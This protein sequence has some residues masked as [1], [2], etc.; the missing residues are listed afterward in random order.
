[1]SKSYPVIPKKLLSSFVVRINGKDQCVPANSNILAATIAADIYVPRLCYHPD[2][3]PAEKCEICLVKVNG[4]FEVLACSTPIQ[5]QM[6]IETKS[7]EVVEHAFKHFELLCNKSVMPSSPEIEEVFKYFYGKGRK[8]TR[9]QEFTNSLVYDPNEC[10]NCER[11][12]RACNVVQQIGAVSKDTYAMDKAK[13][14][15]CGNCVSVCPTMGLREVSAI[16][17]VLRA[18]AAGRTM[19]LQLAPAVRVSVAEL[20]GFPVGTVCTAKIIA[21]AR[22]V[23]FKFVF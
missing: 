11:C 14:I 13:C 1:M 17:S 8:G 6:I 16:P 3:P 10:I 9:Q 4:M 7:K 20:F 22:E 23:G 21:A 12:I 5:D 2:L 19:V 18:L 15:S